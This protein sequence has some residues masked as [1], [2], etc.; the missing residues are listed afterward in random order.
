MGSQADGN[1]KVV[2]E[3]KKVEFYGGLLGAYAPLIFFGL[4]V[5]YVSINGM[6]TMAAYM[7]PLMLVIALV[8]IL[9]KDKRAAYDAMIEGM[10]DR[11]LAVIIIAFIGA[12]V[13]GKI[14]VASGAVEA[15]VWLGY[16]TGAQGIVFLLITFVVAC[17]IASA[18]GTSTGTCVTC[19]PVLYP[20]GVILGAHPALLLGAIYSGARFGD[21]I[22]PISDTT[23]ASA[24]TQGAEIGEVVRTRLK[25]AFVAAGL[26]AVLYIIANFVMGQG[27][28]STNA[29]LAITAS[30]YAK[31]YALLMLLAPATT[32]YLCM[33][34][35]SLMHAIWY[36]I[37]AG[38]VIG[39]LTGS[40]TLQQLYSIKAPKEVTGA[41]TDGVVG[42]R[43]VA[44]LNMFL[45][46]ILGPL[47]RAGALEALVESI[48]KFATTVKRAELSI[49]LLVTF[50]YPLVSANTPAILFA[51][52]IA[53]EIGGKY[54]IHRA[55]VANLL[56]MAGNGVTGNLPHINTILA[57]AAAMIAA[58]EATGVPLVP[59]TTV[60]LFA[61]HPMMLTIVSLFAIATGWGSKQG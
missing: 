21:N 1:V 43:D 60:G 17:I 15:I 13:L 56:D 33:K 29:S 39:L 23:I 49:F 45:M 26:T 52:P 30:E 7:A 18:T 2:S 61:F 57:L 38:I 40:L 31:P 54:N 48:T 42:M 55:R 14:L 4:C 27:T 35:R 6:I 20:A 44:F 34:G 28:Y 51:G 24:T 22:A 50:L 32:V 37:I 41:I 10:S 46:A 16:K 8:L 47:K 58:S 36:G 53:K 5:V 12:G 9:A 11:G 19:V 25:Y 59:I 3:S